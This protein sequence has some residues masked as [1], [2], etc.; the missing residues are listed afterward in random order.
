MGLGATGGGTFFFLVFD[1]SEVGRLD[2]ELDT[3]LPTSGLWPFALRPS[4]ELMDVSEELGENL[5]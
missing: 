1:S 3:F 5:S 4:R 2:D